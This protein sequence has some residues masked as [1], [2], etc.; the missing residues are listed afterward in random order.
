MKSVVVGT[1][2][3]YA[4]KRQA[5]QEDWINNLMP[6]DTFSLSSTYPLHLPQ[7]G[8]RIRCHDEPKG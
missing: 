5:K 3:P 1:C 4:L 6:L 8:M 2:T 7:S